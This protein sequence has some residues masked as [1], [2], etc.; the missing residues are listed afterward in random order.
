MS[1]AGLGIGSTATPTAGTPRAIDRANARRFTAGLRVRIPAADIPTAAARILPARGARPR[2]DPVTSGVHGLLLVPVDA[3]VPSL[4][5]DG[6]DVRSPVTVEVG[7]GEVF[8]RDPAR[9][10]QE[11]FPR[12]SGAVPTAI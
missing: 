12:L 5:A 11:P 4:P 2:N 7:D 10:D 3:H 6:D 1:M 8:H 9:V